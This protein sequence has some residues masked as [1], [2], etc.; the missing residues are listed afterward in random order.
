MSDHTPSWSLLLE[1][2]FAGQLRGFLESF[3]A[4]LHAFRG[5]TV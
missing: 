3:L 2:A 5:L 4:R 1:V